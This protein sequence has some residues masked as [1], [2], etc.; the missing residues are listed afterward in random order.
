MNFIYKIQE[1]LVDLQKKKIDVQKLKKKITVLYKYYKNNRDFFYEGVNIYLS[2]DSKYKENSYQLTN[3]YFANLT[4]TSDL[5]EIK[6]QIDGLWNIWQ[7]IYRNLAVQQQD[8]QLKMD[9]LKTI[10]EILK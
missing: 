1:I 9:H 10:L 5:V 7:P 6:K 2:V 3:E 8:L 4:I